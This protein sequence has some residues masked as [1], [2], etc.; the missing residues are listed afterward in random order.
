MNLSNKAAF[1]L[2]RTLAT[3]IHTS[4]G[5]NPVVRGGM[6]DAKN[7]ILDSI[8]KPETRLELRR[9]FDS[10][11]DLLE[12]LHRGARWATPIDGRSQHIHAELMTAYAADAARDFRPWELW[13][14][15]DKGLANYPD[16]WQTLE[17]HPAWQLN[18]EYRRIQSKEQVG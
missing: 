5:T 12:P 7:D 1:E 6:L 11:L 16:Q 3:S 4:G 8:P 13:E 10:T 9:G 17:R 2:G 15:R 18:T 14:F